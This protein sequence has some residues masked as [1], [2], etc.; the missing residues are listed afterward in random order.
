M[1][2][3]FLIHIK[4]LLAM[5]IVIA[6]M[7]NLSPFGVVQA[8]D[9]P[10]NI[11][12][13]SNVEINKINEVT[14]AFKHPNS[15]GVLIVAVYADNRLLGMATK[16]II[17]GE[18]TENGN[19]TE[20]VYVNIPQNADRI[21]AMIWDGINTMKPL[22]AP[23]FKELNDVE[24]GGS[25]TVLTV[26]QNEDGKDEVTVTFSRPE[27]QYTEGVLIVAAYTGN[28]MLKMVA[29]TVNFQQDKDIFNEKL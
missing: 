13:I 16:S 9:P 22:G 23:T 21:E 10:T 2:D 8:E 17:E 14:V 19:V 20:K 28:M 26:T 1:N 4:K 18:S 27:E 3:K 15:N 12:L 7:V 11:K 24:K 5:L 29:K 25:G 6:L